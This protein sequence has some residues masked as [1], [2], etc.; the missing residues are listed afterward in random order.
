MQSLSDDMAMLRFN[1]KIVKFMVNGTEYELFTVVTQ[2]MDIFRVW[3][4]CDS[5]DLIQL[6]WNV[7]TD[8]IQCLFNC[9]CNPSLRM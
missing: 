6:D 2:Q 4:D 8:N 3:D 1:N 5:P 9:L 7:S